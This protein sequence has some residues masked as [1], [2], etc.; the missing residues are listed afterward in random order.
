[1]TTLLHDPLE[2]C[3][4][5]TLV[6]LLPFKAARTTLDML[7]KESRND[8]PAL[9]HTTF[10][11]SVIAISADAPHVPGRSHISTSST[12]SAFRDDPRRS[13]C[14]SILCSDN[15]CGPQLKLH[16]IPDGN[17]PSDPDL[18]IHIRPSSDVMNPAHSSAHLFI[19]NLA[20]SCHATVDSLCSILRWLCFCSA[21]ALRAPRGPVLGAIHVRAIQSLYTLSR[22]IAYRLA[23]S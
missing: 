15:S 4:N 22:T 20:I 10:P 8:I 16:A 18:I 19:Q 23:A 21:C 12:F 17:G 9:L 2:L 1:M 14:I 11:C 13:G 3:L 6:L 7:R 5:V